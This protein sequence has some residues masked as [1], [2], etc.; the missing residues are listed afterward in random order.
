MDIILIFFIFVLTN[1]SKI[2]VLLFFVNMIHI[3][4]W[5]K[6]IDQQNLQLTQVLKQCT[7]QIFSRH[8]GRKFRGKLCNNWFDDECKLARLNM[9]EQGSQ[10]DTMILYKKLVKRKKKTF[11]KR[12]SLAFSYKFQK[13][14]KAFC[15][16]LRIRSISY[17]LDISTLMTYVE[18]LY[19]FFKLQIY[20]FHL[21]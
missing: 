4:E 13:N 15:A 10:L 12:K 16:H 18:K 1:I 11:I 5:S 6:N 19:H 21:D 7:Y 3:I 17:N 14:P 2:N 20:H 9:M 8:F